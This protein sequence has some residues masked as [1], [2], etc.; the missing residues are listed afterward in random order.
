[1]KWTVCWLWRHSS[2]AG[3]IKEVWRRISVSIPIHLYGS[4]PSEE[5]DQKIT[6]QKSFLMDHLFDLNTWAINAML[7]ITLE[8]Q[9]NDM[10]MQIGWWLNK[11]GYS[12]NKEFH[13]FISC[14]QRNIIFH[15]TKKS[16]FVK[17]STYNMMKY[18][19]NFFDQNTELLLKAWG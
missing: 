12:P 2:C 18:L 4:W 14:R 16:G 3:R 10:T 19:V 15:A 9:K 8:P 13:L 11:N 17:T 5:C 7:L 1:M 6:H